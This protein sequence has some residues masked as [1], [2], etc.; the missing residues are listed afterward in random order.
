VEKARDEQ[1]KFVQGN[2]DARVN[3][4]F[5]VPVGKIAAE[6][7]QSGPATGPAW[8]RQ[9]MVVL[10]EHAAP[11]LEQASIIGVRAG[12]LRLHVAEPALMY[13]LRITW[14]QRL[15]D[16]LQAELPSSGICTVRFTT[17]AHPD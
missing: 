11:L 15:L 5:P 10:S 12:V 7:L 14:E 17:G 6:L 8:R 2:R 3:R 16:V 4:R 13:S 9:L 1:L